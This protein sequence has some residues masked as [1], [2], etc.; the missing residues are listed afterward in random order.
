MIQIWRSEHW[1][2][3][4]YDRSAVEPYLGAAMVAIGEVSGL[5]QGLAPEEQDHLHL[6]HIVQEALASFQIEGVAL[7]PAEVEASVVASLKH[8]NRAGLTRRSDA[9]VELMRTARQADHPLTDQ[10]L[11]AWHR[12]LFFGIEV[13]DPGC[14][15]SFDIE[16]V[17]S[18]AAG[19]DDVLYKAPPPDQVADDMARFL[20]WLNSPSRTPAPIRAALAHLWFESI[21]PFSDGNGRIGRALIEH[22]FAGA[23]ALPFSLSR[24]IES[25]KKAYYAALQAGR[26]EGRG[27]IDA[28]P[29]VSW[30]LQAL[31]RAA[32]TAR[33]E[34]RFLI[35]RNQFFLRVGERLNPRQDKMLRT[36]F[37][38]GADRVGQGIS[39]KSYRRITGAAAATA[40]RDLTAL[41]QAGILT[42]SDAGGRST[43]YWINF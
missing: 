4:D 13:E 36:L 43:A 2:N 10:T 37:E 24:Q 35:R 5:L 40:T 21:H 19:T 23:Q 38:Q 17:R 39:A 30:F 16:I 29:F 32:D 20:D 18:A 41:E 11:F 12:L 1:P 7:N 3:F 28:T 14:W 33:A 26:Q 22:V 42:R 31:E 25:E 15:R 34:A 6:T 27:H 9:V 8:R